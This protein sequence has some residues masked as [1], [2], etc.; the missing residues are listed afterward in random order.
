MKHALPQLYE[1]GLQGR[2]VVPLILQVWAN[3]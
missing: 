1:V 2:P 3:E